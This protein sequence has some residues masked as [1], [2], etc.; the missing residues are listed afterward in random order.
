[1]TA[2]Q[3]L[4][5]GIILSWVP[6]IVLLAWLLW[7]ERVHLNERRKDRHRLWRK[8]TLQRAG[9][10]GPGRRKVKS[11]VRLG[12]VAPPRHAMKFGQQPSCS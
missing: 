3:A 5:Y 10:V 9:S 6:S 7:Q 12:S 4:I 1:M 2:D 11:A 8:E